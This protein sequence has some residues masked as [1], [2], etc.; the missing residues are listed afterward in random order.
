MVNLGMPNEHFKPAF[1]TTKEAA[2]ALNVSDKT[3][4]RLLER[5][6]LQSSKALRKKLIPRKDIDTFFDRTS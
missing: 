3:V 6:L 1:Y 4:R 5:G 2:L